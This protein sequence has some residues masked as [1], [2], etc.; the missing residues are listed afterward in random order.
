MKEFLPY[1]AF[2]LSAVSVGISA[3]VA[4]RAARWRADEAVA[5]MSKRVRD[6]EARADLIEHRV[7]DLEEKVRELPTKADFTRLEGQIQRTCAIADRTEAS[8]TRI[9][10]YLMDRR[11]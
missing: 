2:L 4:V 11:P 5:A 1:G 6:A 3:W 10:G 9:E 8:V 7:D